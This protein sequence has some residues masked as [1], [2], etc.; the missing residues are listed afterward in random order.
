MLRQVLALGLLGA[1]GRETALGVGSGAS[2][3][4][5]AAATDA[6]FV[7]GQVWAYKTNSGEEESTVTILRVET[8]GK[9]GTIVHVRVDGLHFRNCRGETLADNLPH[10]PFARAALEASV[11]KQIGRVSTLP[12]FEEGYG[13]WLRDCGGVY[14]VSVAQV[15]A[16]DERTYPANLGCP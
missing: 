7:P 10:A 5:P 11:T 14:T 2:C 15:V 12:A 4:A 6:K 8:L 16:L 9:V 3:A 13:I 1:L